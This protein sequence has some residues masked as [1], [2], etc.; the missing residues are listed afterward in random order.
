MVEAIYHTSKKM[1]ST[2]WELTFLQRRLDVATLFWRHRGA[3]AEWSDGAAGL[4]S[5]SWDKCGLEG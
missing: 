3:D 2:V 4:V 5:L 1:L